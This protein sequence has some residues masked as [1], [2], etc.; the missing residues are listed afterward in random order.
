MTARWSVTPLLFANWAAV[1]IGQ[2]REQPPLP[3]PF[4]Q[5]SPI[6]TFR[7]GV[8][9]VQVDVYVTDQDGLISR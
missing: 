1:L 2:A 4:P 9:L 5:R 8:E 6:P 3:E 7:S